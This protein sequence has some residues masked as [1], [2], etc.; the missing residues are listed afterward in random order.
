MSVVK[1]KREVGDLA[2]I[3][4]AAELARYTVQ[5]CTNE[6]NFPKRFRW[7]IT[8]KIVDCAVDINIYLNAANSVFVE[9]PE[10]FRIRQSYQ[11]KALALTHSLVATIKVAHKTFNIEASRRECWGRKIQ[12]VRALTQSWIRAD[13]E[14]Y[15]KELKAKGF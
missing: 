8:N 1:S 10:D 9:Y 4:A 11:K 12:N 14:R 7:A 15:T 2:V 5:V 6:N 3:T 13:K